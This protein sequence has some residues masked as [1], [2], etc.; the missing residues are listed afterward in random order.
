[1]YADRY[2]MKK[3]GLK[4][5]CYCSGFPWENGNA[6][7]R[8]GSKSESNGWYCYFPTERQLETGVEP[9]TLDSQE[10]IPS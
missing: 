4:Q 3:E 6:P 8:R 7:H 2:R 9:D 5:G 10:P 1:M